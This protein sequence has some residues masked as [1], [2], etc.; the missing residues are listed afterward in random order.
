[1]ATEHELVVSDFKSSRSAWNGYKVEDQAPQ[2]LL[3][4]ELVKPLA[5]GRPIKLTFAVLTKTKAPVLTEHD[6]PLDPQ[7]VDRTKRIVERVWH[8]IQAG[9][10]FPNPS[11]LNCASCP[12]HAPICPTIPMIDS[13]LSGF[14]TCSV[15]G[16]LIP[17]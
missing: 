10:F 17:L 5:D 9:H 6:L 4:S 12:F 2:L 14:P 7:E 15:A 11:P 16:S 1:M 13:L 3:Y 8:A